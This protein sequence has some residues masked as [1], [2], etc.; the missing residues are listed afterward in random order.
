MLN[1]VTVFANDRYFVLCSYWT[2]IRRAISDVYSQITPHFFKGKI[3]QISTMFIS[4][5][6][7]FSW[8][9][10]DYSSYMT[11]ALPETNQVM[12]GT[13]CLI[14]S[15]LWSMCCCMIPSRSMWELLD[16]LLKT[17]LHTTVRMFF[18]YIYTLSGIIFTEITKYL[19][20]IYIF[21]LFCCCTYIDFFK[22]LHF[23]SLFCDIYG[24]IL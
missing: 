24:S 16:Q 8:T 22:H 20:N 13:V 12:P 10:S 5:K 1:W 14:H 18:F 9:P 6:V 4:G 3:L 21:V 11:S 23:K 17:E 2:W 19:N 15:T 7:R